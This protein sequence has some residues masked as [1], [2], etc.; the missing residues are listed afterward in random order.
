MPR[1]AVWDTKGELAPF[2]RICALNKEASVCIPTSVKIVTDTRNGRVRERLPRYPS[3]GTI[4]LRFCLAEALAYRSV[5]DHGDH[6]SRIIIIIDFA[7]GG[8]RFLHMY[9]HV[10]MRENI[11]LFT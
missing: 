9:R 1:I 10:K 2:D 7:M 11:S 4:V 3:R 8:D 5:T 6:V